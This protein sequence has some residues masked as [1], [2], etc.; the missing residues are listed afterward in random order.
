MTLSQFAD[1]ADLVAAI[2]VIGTML[3]LAYELHQ[4]NKEA[5]LSNWR[6]LLDSFRDYKSTTNDLALSELIERGNQSYIGLNP[7]EQRSYGQYLEQGIHVMG[8][9]SKHT[10]K[11]PFELTGLNTAVENS[12][13]DLLNTP[14]GREWWQEY[15][16]KGKL[17][18][19]SYLMIDGLLDGP[20]IPKT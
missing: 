3:F 16:P 9:F 10:G 7:L 6:Q 1:I 11:V 12:M 19:S 18:P 2:G 20:G 13:L 8:N 14:G 15:K 4:S 17:L 5:R